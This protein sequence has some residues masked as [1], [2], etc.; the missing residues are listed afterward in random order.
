MIMAQYDA[1]LEQARM[2]I[3]DAW[4]TKIMR[5]I[6]AS[7][8]IEK[9]RTMAAMD[10]GHDMEWLLDV[11]CTEQACA[12]CDGEGKIDCPKCDGEGRLYGDRDIECP[13]CTG[14]HSVECPV[15]G[16][17]DGR[18]ELGEILEFWIVEDR[19]ERRLKEAGETMID[20]TSIGLGNAIWCRRCSGQAISL[21][22]VVMDCAEAFALDCPWVLDPV[23]ADHVA[24]WTAH[25][26]QSPA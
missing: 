1:K 10:D 25:R 17:D 9:F 8:M 12:K 6:L 21:D 26:G 13:D 7:G 14:D 3:A 18:V 20:A 23:H 5:P 2:A 22:G 15:E 19:A 24:Y 11:L 4:V 16:C